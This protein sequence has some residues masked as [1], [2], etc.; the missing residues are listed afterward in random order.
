MDPGLGRFKYCRA[1]RRNCYR[2]GRRYYCNL[3]RCFAQ[4]SRPHTDQTEKRL[5]VTSNLN[6][7]QFHL[8]TI[9]FAAFFFSQINN[10]SPASITRKTTCITKDTRL[11]RCYKRNNVTTD[12]TCSQSS[13]LS[14]QITFYIKKLQI[15]S[16]YVLVVLKLNE[17]LNIFENAIFFLTRFFHVD[18]VV[19]NQSVNASATL[20][21]RRPDL[22]DEL[23]YIAPPNRKLP[24]V[25][26][27]NYNTC[28]RIKRGTISKKLS[29]SVA[30]CSFII[31][32]RNH[33]PF[34]IWNNL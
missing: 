29:P 2:S 30:A 11:L 15:L 9:L 23:G 17:A 10:Q 13:V 32:L 8:N 34:F 25:P 20:D 4:S 14:C 16:N 28:D 27:S 19:Y 21:K 31:F 6:A 5:Y 1:G 7:P 24:P 26:G 12:K 22:R 3:C 18:D 33:P